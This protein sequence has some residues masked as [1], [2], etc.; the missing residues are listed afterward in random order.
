MSRVRR[1]AVQTIDAGLCSSNC[2]ERQLAG[3]LVGQVA[4]DELEARRTVD[5]YSGQAMVTPA[6]YGK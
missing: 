3:H 4:V 5:L 2:Y 1:S 6:S